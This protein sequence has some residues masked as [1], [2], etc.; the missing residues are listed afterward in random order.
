ML[1]YYTVLK[2]KEYRCEIEKSKFIASVSPAESKEEAMQF[3]SKIK[4]KYKD[5]THNVPAFVLGPKFDSSWASD[6][7]EPQGTAGVPI[8]QMLIKEG[9]TNVATVVTRYFGGVKLGTGGLVRAYTYTAKQGIVEAGI[10]IVKNMRLLRYEIAYSTLSSIESRQ[11]EF[12]YRVR[13][14]IYTDKVQLDLLLEIEQEGIIKKY[15][16]DITKGNSR[17]IS[18]ETILEKNEVSQLERKGE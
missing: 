1:E 15:L 13:N 8:M 12:N 6:D 3:I 16:S 17:L 14:I 9:V 10:C 7:G 11:K 2:E 18:E 4:A 5:A